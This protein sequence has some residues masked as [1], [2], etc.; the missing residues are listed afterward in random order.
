M[1]QFQAELRKGVSLCR[2][3]RCRDRGL[4]LIY[5]TGPFSYPQHRPTFIML[6]ASLPGTLHTTVTSGSSIYHIIRDQRTSFS[7]RPRFGFHFINSKKSKMAA[8]WYRSILERKNKMYCDYK[9]IIELSDWENSYIKRALSHN[10][11]YRLFNV[12]WRSLL[13]MCSLGVQLTK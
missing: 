6:L 1:T 8:L 5:Q 3:S 9:T 4:L 10:V 12:G 13:I 7:F 11:H 2:F